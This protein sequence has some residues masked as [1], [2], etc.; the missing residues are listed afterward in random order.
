MTGKAEGDREQSVTPPQE[1]RT[2]E[3]TPP[4]ERQEEEVTP[5]QE[6]S[7]EEA[8]P[9]QEHRGEEATPPQKEVQDETSV[10]SSKV[11]VACER[12]Y[13]PKGKEVASVV[14]EMHDEGVVNGSTRH[15]KGALFELGVC[16]DAREIRLCRRG[17]TILHSIVGSVRTY[18]S[19]HWQP[20]RRKATNNPFGWLRQ[21]PEAAELIRRALKVARRIR[22]GPVKSYASPAWVSA[23]LG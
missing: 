14:Q 16:T 9:L 18:L 4:R 15:G 10:L 5:P 20:R 7:G 8:T 23:A 12:A 2:T 3:A 6:R 17:M 1:S 11:L 22:K 19:A 21:A 13:N